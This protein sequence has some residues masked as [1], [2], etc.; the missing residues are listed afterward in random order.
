MMSPTQPP[1]PRR[2]PSHPEIPQTRDAPLAR[3]N[4]TVHDNTFHKS[5]SL[6]DLPQEV[7][8]NIYQ[9]L[10]PEKYGIGINISCSGLENAIPPKVDFSSAPPS[11][12]IELVC[13][14]T[15]RDTHLLRKS[16]FSR[17]LTVGFTEVVDWKALRWCC[18]N[19][20]PWICGCV[21]SL[22]LDGISEQ[23][24]GNCYWTEEIWRTL[25][26]LI[27]FPTLQQV[28]INF[29]LVK[30]KE[31]YNEWSGFWEYSETDEW[32]DVT[33]VDESDILSV[34]RRNACFEAPAYMINPFA[35][36]GY[37]IERSSDCT[38]YLRTTIQ[39]ISNSE[40]KI[41]LREDVS[42]MDSAHTL[43]G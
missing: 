30:G 4:P 21:T 38:V 2:E 27:P 40:S 12:G 41:L 23:G 32:H 7:L 25:D 1:R 16:A 20:F 8:D 24:L 28:Q 3:S 17:E 5:P 43:S 39:W 33:Q 15:R 36:A 34:D 13:R 35:L 6:L 37:M 26:L 29:N 10:Y 9:H 19:L 42:S 31:W 14:K 22:L 18:S 11:Y